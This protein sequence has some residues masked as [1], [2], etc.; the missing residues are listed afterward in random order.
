MY[1][2]TLKI[3]DKK[4]YYKISLDNIYSVTGGT[5]NLYLNDQFTEITSSIVPKVNVSEIYGDAYYLDLSS[6]NLDKDN[7]NI[8][9]L[10][11]MSLNFNTYSINPNVGYKFKY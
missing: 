3:V 6:L 10:R 1:I 5:V 8:F 11:I 9:E 2:T 4:L 7:I